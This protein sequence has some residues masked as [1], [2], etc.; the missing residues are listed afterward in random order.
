MLSKCLLAAL[1]IVAAV[2]GEQSQNSSQ[3]PIVDLGYQLQRATLFNVRTT[4]YIFE[5]RY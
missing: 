3:L 4:H 2:A 5:D 1:T